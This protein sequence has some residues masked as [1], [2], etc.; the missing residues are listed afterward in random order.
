MSTPDVSN[1][2]ALAGSSPLPTHAFSPFAITKSISLS[3]LNFHS[4]AEISDTALGLTISPSARILRVF[5][6]IRVYILSADKALSIYKRMTIIVYT[7]DLTN[8]KLSV[9]NCSFS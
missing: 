6:F 4:R 1:F 8:I 7:D 5:F 9:K 3:S 2:L